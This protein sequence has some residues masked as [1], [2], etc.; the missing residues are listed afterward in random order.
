MSE[1]IDFPDR[2]RTEEEAAAW[3]LRPDDG[4]PTRAEWREFLSRYREDA[5]FRRAFRELAGAWDALDALPQA[6]GEGG[7]V[8]SRQATE[9]TAAGRVREPRAGR[10]A[11]AAA[12]AALAALIVA[13]VLVSLLTAPPVAQTNGTY[14][15]GV[16]EQH[17]LTLIDGS[18]IALN[19]NTQLKVAYAEDRRL[20]LLDRGEAHFEVAAARDWPFVVRARG[21]E[22]Q[23]LGTAFTVYLRGGKTEVTVTEGRVS[24][25]PA[26]PRAAYEDAAKAPPVALAAGQ[27]AV[28]DEE[29]ETVGALDAAE[30]RRRLAWREGMLAFQGETLEEVVTEVARYTDARIEIADPGLR[31]LRIGG[32]FPA[33]RLDDLLR[34]LDS[35]F[36]IRAERR[37]DGVIRLYPAPPASGDPE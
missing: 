35:G 4:E 2:R 24:V 6:L 26:R 20:L 17:R 23:A 29:V 18:R 15:T 32:Y 5:A 9:R 8:S 1:V 30:I 28:Y 7:G 34:A 3:V 12:G 25:V 33:N 10:R 22:V 11:L 16:G 19:T 31:G 36:G 13:A 37:P 21:G 27:R 14:L